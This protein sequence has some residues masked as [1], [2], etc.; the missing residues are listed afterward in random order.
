MEKS[1]NYE[2][3]RMRHISLRQA[4]LVIDLYASVGWGTVEQYNAEKVSRSL[5]NSYVLFAQSSEGRIIGMTRALS[6]EVSVTWVAEL[7]VEPPMQ[8]EGIGAQLLSKLVDDHCGTDIY[9]E[10]FGTGPTV[11][12][13][14]GFQY[15]GAGRVFSKGA[16]RS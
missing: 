13:R 12:E 7:I 1:R 10:T 15:K 9:L 16:T 8:N 2:I 14:C 5:S 6:D 4:E 3:I 11:F